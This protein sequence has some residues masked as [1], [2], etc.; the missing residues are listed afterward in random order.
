MIVTARLAPLAEIQFMREQYRQ[1]MH[2]QIIH[3]SI[4]RRP[5]WSREYALELDGLVAGYGSLAID[6]PWRDSHALYE[7]FVLP[8]HPD[9]NLPAV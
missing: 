6:G 4:H 2:C 1:Q 9:A 3:D 7:F 5:G 8:E